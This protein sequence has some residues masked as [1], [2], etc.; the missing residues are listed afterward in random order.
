MK[1]L[2]GIAYAVVGLL[3]LVIILL[4]LF[5]IIGLFQIIISMI[6]DKW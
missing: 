6:R 3:G 5:S 4:L 1:V 2:I